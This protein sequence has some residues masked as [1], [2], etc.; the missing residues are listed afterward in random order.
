MNHGVRKPVLSFLVVGY[1]A[2][3]A[4]L[5]SCGFTQVTEQPDLVTAT[6]DLDLT[7]LP[8]S[9][10]M[11]RDY[12]LRRPV[13]G[14]G[15][16]THI[17][18]DI[19]GDGFEEAFYHWNHGLVCSTGKEPS[20]F[21]ELWQVRLPAEYGWDRGRASLV[22]VPD[23]LGPGR[24]GV[25]VTC[26]HLDRDTWCT[27]Y[28]DPESRELLGG[29]TVDA[30][31]D[32]KYDNG[33]WDGNF[34]PAGALSIPGRDNAV[35]IL[36]CDV[37]FD[38]TGR[39]LIAVDPLAGEICWRF[40]A[41]PHFTLRGTRIVDLEGDGR[42][43][44]VLSGG[45]VDNLHGELIGFASDDT[46]RIVVVDHDGTMRWQRPLLPY[47]SGALLE[48]ADLDADGDL[49]VVA[50]SSWGTEGVGYLGAWNSQGDLIAEQDYDTTIP[51]FTLLPRVENGGADIV[52]RRYMD[53]IEVVRLQGN[54]FVSV[55]ALESPAL[56]SS[57]ASEDILPDPGHEV[58][59][60]ISGHGI[61]ILGSEL[62]LLARINKPLVR[63]NNMIHAWRLKD[64]KTFLAPFILE[65]GLYRFDPVVKSY[66]GFLKA[67]P[68]LAFVMLVGLVF[69]RN[70]R[71]DGH[72]D[73][74]IQA[75]LRGQL[76]DRLATADHGKIGALRVLRR[77]SWRLRG[78]VATGDDLSSLD[79]LLGE[80]R[81]HT[82][83]ALHDII[84]LSA[85]CGLPDHVVETARES[86]NNLETPLNRL[87]EDQSTNMATVADQL[88][89]NVVEAE[90]ALVSLRRH[91]LA[92]FTCDVTP[93]CARVLKAQAKGL[94]L[95]VPA[96][97]AELLPPG[98]SMG[99]ELSKTKLDGP[100]TCCLDPRD[101]VFIMDNLVENAARHMNGQ[102]TPTLHLSW[103]VVGD[104]LLL[105]VADSGPGVESEHRA[106]LFE[107][108][109][110]TAGSSGLGL[111]KSRQIL[112]RF[113]GDVALGEG[114]GSL[115]GAVFL[116]TLPLRD[117][118]PPQKDG[119]I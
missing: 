44:V 94:W 9:S 42:S 4:F 74:A 110:S 72:A 83:P 47:S 116:V 97:V 81:S 93:V 23:L 101:L 10:V 31:V 32:Q 58:V 49:E 62:D 55:R 52:I 114:Q 102:E 112:R 36:V 41:G 37:G 105:T 24:P 43:E 26:R 60:S 70:A 107:E 16:P 115:G 91:T 76:L 19:D 95:Q 88:E 27:W 68:V 108:G 82:L 34:A 7:D 57:L 53:R 65:R 13:V 1:L 15:G 2:L 5:L 118:G 8:Y 103:V 66:S 51:S 80:V 92:S 12:I 6:L 25:I 54:A 35:A 38:A 18:I 46:S 11:M 33:K 111:A 20:G 109:F 96:K 98:L 113:G 56:L 73:Q 21:R 99:L 75:E 100:T 78:L 64:D 14:R 79:D 85:R 59:L 30:P 90:Q 40:T 117:P 50:S 87:A 17:W 104:Q 22:G 29:V 48:V 106:R 3:S 67:W 69:W 28:L 119:R 63:G 45:A 89:P 86:L 61:W 39:G 71:R 77:L 84:Q